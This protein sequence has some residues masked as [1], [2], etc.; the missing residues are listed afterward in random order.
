[1]TKRQIGEER[2]YLSYT[3]ISLFAIKGSQDWN[4]NRTGKL[5][6]VVDVETMD[7]AYWLPP[8]SCSTCFLLDPNT[9]NPRQAPS[10]RG[11]VLP[12]NH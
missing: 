2:V 1:M 9:T 4:T 7:T 8:M 12:I 6:T 3:S 11:Y 5:E 10:I